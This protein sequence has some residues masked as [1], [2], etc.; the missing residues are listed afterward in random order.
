MLSNFNQATRF[1][2][3]MRFALLRP[4]IRLLRQMASTIF[5]RQGDFVTAPEL[6]PLFGQTLGKAL[7][8]VL[9]PLQ[10]CGV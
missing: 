1:D 9:P 10:W 6:S 2:E 3:F 7:R 4:P 5:G 8:E